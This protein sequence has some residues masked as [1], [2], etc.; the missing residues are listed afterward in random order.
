MTLTMPVF[1]SS[2]YAVLL[3]SC[4]FYVVVSFNVGYFLLFLLSL[5][6]QLLLAQISLALLRVP[7]GQYHQQK[8]F[9]DYIMVVIR[10]AKRVTVLGLD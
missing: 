7:K 6:P 2:Y 8:I 10:V 9:D 4:H 5:R 3:V 1:A